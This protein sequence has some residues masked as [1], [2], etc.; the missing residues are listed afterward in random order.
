MMNSKRSSRHTVW[1]YFFLLPVFTVLVCALNEPA[2]YAQRSKKDSTKKAA[3]NPGRSADKASPASAASP[4]SA[5]SSSSVASPASAVSPASAASPGSASSPASEAKPALPDTTVRPA[6]SSEGNSDA[7]SISAYT[8][9]YPMPMTVIAP[10]PAL[11]ESLGTLTTVSPV[12]A[13]LATSPVHATASVHV[14]ASPYPATAAYPATSV[15]V[16]VSP[17]PA[18]APRVNPFPAVT[19]MEELTDGAWF[20]TSKDSKLWFELKA[21]EED[22]SWSHT[23]GVEKSEINPFPGVG[24]VTFKLVRE[25]G[26]ITFTGQFDGQQGFGRFH[27]EA[28]DNYFK[29]LQQQGVEEVDKRKMSFFSLNIKKDYVAMVQRNG[30]PHIAGRELLSFAA[31]HIDQEFLQYWKGSGLVDADDP[32][33]LVSIKSMQ[34]D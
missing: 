17:Y 31:M 25:A 2:V 16:A 29:S 1:K 32:R 28:D 22:H 4:S 33:T 7:I 26:T 6:G 30:F 8:A 5:A 24:N 34:I 14:T 9:P 10:M 18:V 15:H 13:V 19:I 12:V 20:V 11:T 27:F 23:L 21:E 3:T